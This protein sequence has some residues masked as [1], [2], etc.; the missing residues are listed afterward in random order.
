LSATAQRYAAALAARMA[1]ERAEALLRRELTP[2][3]EA[4][5]IQAFVQ[6]LDRSVH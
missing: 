6:E 3:S 1:V 2:K 4:A 5:L